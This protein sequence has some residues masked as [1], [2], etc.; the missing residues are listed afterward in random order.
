LVIDVGDIYLLDNPEGGY[1]RDEKRE[2]MKEK[3]NRIYYIQ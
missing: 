1:K 2:P 3:Y